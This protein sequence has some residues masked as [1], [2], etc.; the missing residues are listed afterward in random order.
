MS[1]VGKSPTFYAVR[2]SVNLGKPLVYANELD[3]VGYIDN[4]KD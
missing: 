1:E 2:M 3:L 4:E